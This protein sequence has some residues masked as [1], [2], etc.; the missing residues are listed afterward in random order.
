M[1]LTPPMARKPLR[2][3]VTSAIQEM[4][5]ASAYLPWST[6][7]KYLP[8]EFHLQF[9]DEGVF[10]QGPSLAICTPTCAYVIQDTALGQKPQAV[11]LGAVAEICVSAYYA[12]VRI[13][14]LVSLC[15]THQTEQSLLRQ[16][17]AH[18]LVE[19]HAIYDLFMELDK[20]KPTCASGVAAQQFIQSSPVFKEYLDIAQ[21]PLQQLTRFRHKHGA[22]HGLSAF[23]L[24]Q[25]GNSNSSTLQASHK[26][27]WQLADQMLS[28]AAVTAVLAKLARPVRNV[29]SHLGALSCFAVLPSKEQP[30]IT[31]IGDPGE[32]PTGQVMT[33]Y[34]SAA[35]EQLWTPRSF[36]KLG[37]PTA[38]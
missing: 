1:T 32:P 26:E 23:A 20:A 25:L 9:L 29:I 17:F 11:P 22:H 4:R 5:G 37:K 28:P 15:A 30:Y 35:L 18:A 10:E 38:K 12:W 31:I 3:A 14:R 2:Q 13:K 33:T 8:T 34:L 27:L 21:G 7:F 6:F 36:L 24:A 19:A 16:L